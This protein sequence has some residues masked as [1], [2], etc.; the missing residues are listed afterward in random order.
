MNS[1]YSLFMKKNLVLLAPVL[2]VLLFVS[3]K[4][5]VTKP[6]SERIKKTWTAV[7]VTEGTVIKYDKTATTNASPGYA[8]YSINLT[9]APTAV[10]KEVDGSTFT[11]TYSLSG[12]TKLVLSGLNPAPTGTGGTIEFTIDSISDTELK[13]TRTTINQKTGGTINKY[14]LAGI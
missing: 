10:L 3:C 14:T 7:Q 2:F 9:N 6:V 13:L 8:N 12:D 5:T 11:G 1:I 4:K